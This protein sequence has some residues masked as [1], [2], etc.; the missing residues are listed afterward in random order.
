MLVDKNV[1]E[2]ILLI[3]K[4]IRVNFERSLWMIR[5]HPLWIRNPIGKWWAMRKYEKMI[6][7]MT[8]K[9]E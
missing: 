7:E 4:I 3:F 5:F 1:A 8:N 2:Y 9:N 6:K